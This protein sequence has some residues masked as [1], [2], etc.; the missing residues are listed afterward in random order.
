MPIN[1]LDYLLTDPQFSLCEVVDIIDFYM[2]GED[3]EKIEEVKEDMRHAF[4]PQ[5]RS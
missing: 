2:Q 3:K 4:Q 1:L 5:A